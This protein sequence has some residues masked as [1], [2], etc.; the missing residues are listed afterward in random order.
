MH[1]FSFF[2]LALFHLERFAEAKKSLEEGQQ[3][4]GRQCWLVNLPHWVALVA[5]F[6]PEVLNV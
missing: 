3:L 2:S 5:N 6:V 1:D 4:D